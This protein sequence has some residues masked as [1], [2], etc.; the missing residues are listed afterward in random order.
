MD[1]LEMVHHQ[2]VHS[3]A[4]APWSDTQRVYVLVFCLQGALFVIT[5]RSSALPLKGASSSRSQ[6]VVPFIPFS[7]W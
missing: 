2:S 6:P 4:L 1:A 5:C 3:V 7:D